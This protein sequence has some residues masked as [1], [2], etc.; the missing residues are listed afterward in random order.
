MENQE[1][2]PNLETPKTTEEPTKKPKPKWLI[3]VIVIAGII[4]LGLIVCG[5]FEVFKSPTE[6]EEITEDEFKDWEIYRNE[7][8]G[9]EFKYPGDWK[10]IKD[11]VEEVDSA[12]LAL[13]KSDAESSFYNCPNPGVAI[14]F[15]KNGFSDK[16]SIENKYFSIEEKDVII[17]NI[18]A[19]KI[20]RRSLNDNIVV[21]NEIY[22]EKDNPTISFS[23]ACENVIKD[24]EK[25]YY[26]LI[27][28]QIL[29]TFKF[30]N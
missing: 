5:A 8:Y 18:P 2:K 23:V 11:T 29:S 25:E 22:L 6:P 17:A 14:Q 26:D 4:V 27:F 12:L 21:S 9:F 7:E 13:A 30:I 19:K 20:I 1:Q 15:Q 28:N 10:M 16:V 24:S 3:S